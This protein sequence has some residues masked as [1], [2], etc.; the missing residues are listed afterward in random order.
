VPQS[1]ERRALAL[2]VRRVAQRAE[3]LDQREPLR[4]EHSVQRARPVSRVRA[5]FLYVPVQPAR[6]AQPDAPRAGELREDARQPD[7]REPQ[8]AEVGEPKRA[9]A[10]ARVLPVAAASAALSPVQVRACRARCGELFR[11]PRMGWNWS[12]SSFPLHQ[13]PARDR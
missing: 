1:E 7:V 2:P 11:Q 12:G 8:L 6:V 13:A 3:P 4:E 9:P 5:Q 10:S